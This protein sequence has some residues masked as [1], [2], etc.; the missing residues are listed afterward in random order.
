MK[1]SVLGCTCMSIVKKIESNFKA[2]F[3]FNCACFMQ[4]GQSNWCDIPNMYS[5]G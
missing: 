1:K 2:K 4:I 3:H 5:K